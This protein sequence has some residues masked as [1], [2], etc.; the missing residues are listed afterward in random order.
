M[1]KRTIISTFSIAVAWLIIFL[2]AV[3]PHNH[4]EEHA[5]DC[6]SVYHCCHD[7]NT[8][9]AISHEHGV[10]GLQELNGSHSENE[11]HFIC[12]FTAGPLHT[13]DND[14]PFMV[15]KVAATDELYE[16]SIEG[17]KQYVVPYIERQRYAPQ[18]R[19]GPPSL[20]G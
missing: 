4:H 7:S 15:N 12:H 18:N 2:H 13:L 1:R 20:M 14:T 17:F 11:S 6:K 9:G 5:D 10:T 19:R 3:I 16:K 8:S